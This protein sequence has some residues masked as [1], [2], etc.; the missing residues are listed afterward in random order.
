MV[1]PGPA[2]NF[3][4][5][6]TAQT[7]VLENDCGHLGPGCEQAKVSAAIAEFLKEK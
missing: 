6:K 1:T 2:L 5:L 4:K 7:L 3:A